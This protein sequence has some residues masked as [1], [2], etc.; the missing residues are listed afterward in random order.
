MQL[1]SCY[2]SLCIKE[3]LQHDQVLAPACVTLTNT[4]AETLFKAPIPLTLLIVGKDI[5]LL[6]YKK[7]NLSLDLFNLLL[8][9]PR[10]F[11]QLAPRPIQSKTCNIS[12]SF[13]AIAK[14]PLPQVVE[15]A[16]KITY[17]L[18]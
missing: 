4:S 8:Y 5:F 3:R 11:A 14:S 18:Y 7:T 1:I 17:S 2:Y 9:S 6:K 15:T 10:I 13:S 12:V 16:G